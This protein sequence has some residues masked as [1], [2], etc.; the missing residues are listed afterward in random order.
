MIDSHYK[1]QKP[2]IPTMQ[3]QVDKMQP[4]YDRKNIDI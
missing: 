4:R 3:R 2:D 1:G